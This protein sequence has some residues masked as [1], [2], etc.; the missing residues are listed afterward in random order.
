[1]EVVHFSLP[2][3]V[4]FYFTID[5]PSLQLK[6]GTTIS[7]MRINQAPIFLVIMGKKSSGDAQCESK[8]LLFASGPN[9][10]RV[11]NNCGNMVRSPNRA[12]SIANPVNKPK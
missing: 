5:T 8:S 1:M 12:T 10:F 11:I 9:G 6:N 4:Q 7:K 2:F 3:L